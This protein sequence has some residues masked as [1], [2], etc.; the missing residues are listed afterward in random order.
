MAVT[1]HLMM[2][3]INQYRQNDRT[4]K[5]MRYC[6]LVKGSQK[7]P[8]RFKAESLLQIG[9]IKFGIVEER[10][11]DIEA[12]PPFKKR[13]LANFIDGTGYFN[14]VKFLG[15]NHH[16]FPYLYKLACCLAA[17][18]RN[19]VGCERFFSIASY[20]SNPRRT[21]LKI[22]ITRPWQC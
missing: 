19:E 21:Q 12:T 2:S 11:E 9:L 5:W 1:T 13:N 6:A 3:T 18:R 14:L 15:F 20:V 17:M 22:S 4:H 10:G 16:V 7:Y 8:K